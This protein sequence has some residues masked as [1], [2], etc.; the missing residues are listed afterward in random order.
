MPINDKELNITDEDLIASGENMGLTN[1]YCMDVIN[2][3]KN[4]VG[5]WL[6]YADKVGIGEERA[7]EV[8]EH[9]KTIGITN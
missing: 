8:L 3:T 4:I 5:N 2:E 1:T 6:S 9:I 7:N